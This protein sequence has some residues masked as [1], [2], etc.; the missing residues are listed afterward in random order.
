MAKYFLTNK[1]VEDLAAIW[2]YTYDTWSER[3][4]DKYHEMLTSSFQEILEHPD[5][6]KKYPEID[7]SVMGLRVGKH[8]VFYRMV[9]S[10][11]IEVLRILHQ[12]MDLK[13]RMQD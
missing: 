5:L 2:E 11:D 1:A 6:G 13:S 9:Q 7:T 12:R 10:S 3:Q 4:A 8:I